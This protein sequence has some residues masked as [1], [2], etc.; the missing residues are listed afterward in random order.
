LTIGFPLVDVLLLCVPFA[1]EARRVAAD[2]PLV[3]GI[4]TISQE[5]DAKVKEI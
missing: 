1:G 4:C 2:T 3:R 5:K